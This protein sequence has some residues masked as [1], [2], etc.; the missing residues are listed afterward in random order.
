MAKKKKT[1]AEE[2]QELVE[3]CAER[4]ALWKNQRATGVSDP[5]WSDGE[6]LNLV[7]NHIKYAKHRIKEHCAKHGMVIP[8]IYYRPMPPEMPNDFYVVTGKHYQRRMEL[9][10]RIDGK[11]KQLSLF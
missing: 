10:E 2:L 1:A 7:R 3:E 8:A 9:K 6:N 5:F 4:Y 11:S